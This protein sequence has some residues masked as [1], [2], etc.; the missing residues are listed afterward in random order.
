MCLWVQCFANIMLHVWV[1]S[2]LITKWHIIRSC[3]MG[4][5]GLPDIYTL[6]PQA[7]GVYITQT[8]LAHVTTTYVILSHLR[9]KVHAVLQMSCSPP[10]SAL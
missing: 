6:S 5:H 10:H 2:L 8:T 9:S 4:T 1:C 3:N 7:L